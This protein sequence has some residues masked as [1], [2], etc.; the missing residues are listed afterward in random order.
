MN[1]W[2]RPSVGGVDVYTHGEMLPA[3]YYP[4]F[5]QYD[6]FAG[7]YGNSWWLQHRE[8]E[9]FNGPI[10]MTTNCL[11]PPRDSYKNRL[12]TTGLVAFPG[13]RHIPDRSDAPG[14]VKDFSAVIDHALRCQPP[15]ELERGTIT[16]GF[17]HAQVTQLADTVVAAVKSGAIKRFVVMAGCDGPRRGTRILHR[18]RASTPARYGDSDRR[19]REISLQQARSRYDRRRSTGTGRRPMQR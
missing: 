12:Y 8:F 4:T 7:N 19:V 15:T 1:C 13:I 18:G 17:A 9:S 3:H 6:H 14:A 10:V 2:N 5:K 11:T 16:G